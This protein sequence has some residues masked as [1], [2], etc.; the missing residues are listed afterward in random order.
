[1]YGASLYTIPD[2]SEILDDMQPRIKKK[3]G[4]KEKEKKEKN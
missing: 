2:T 3:I 4:I 1:V